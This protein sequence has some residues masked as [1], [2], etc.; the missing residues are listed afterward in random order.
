MTV[1][2]SNNLRI[3]SVLNTC[4]FRTTRI[5]SKY[6][7]SHSHWEMDLYFKDLRRFKYLYHQD[8][9]V[10][11]STENWWFTKMAKGLSLRYDRSFDLLY[12]C[13]L[14]YPFRTV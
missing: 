4:W 9:R 13:D 11:V 3:Y 2:N 10:V 12:F 5:L 1:S 14:R 7:T 8:I 6:H